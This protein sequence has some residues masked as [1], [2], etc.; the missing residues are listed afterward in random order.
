MEIAERYQD[1]TTS[2]GE[3]FWAGNAVWNEENEVEKIVAGQDSGLFDCNDPEYQDFDNASEK[4]CG[5]GYDP[6]ISMGST[7]NRFQYIFFAKTIEN[8]LCSHDVLPNGNLGIF[9]IEN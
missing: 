1:T 9:V 5:S 2:D 8:E 6:P 3:V 7:E 4:A